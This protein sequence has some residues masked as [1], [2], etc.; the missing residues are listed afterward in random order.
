[1]YGVRTKIIATYPFPKQ[2]QI[3]IEADS[4]KDLPRGSYSAKSIP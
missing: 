2:G 1:M 3:H 4:I